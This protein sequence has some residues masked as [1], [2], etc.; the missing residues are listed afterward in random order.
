MK[1]INHLTNRISASKILQNR[2][3]YH[4]TNNLIPLNH[5]RSFNML[6]MKRFFSIITHENNSNEIYSLATFNGEEFLWK[7]RLY[8]FTKQDTND[9]WKILQVYME[10]DTMI[11][12]SQQQQQQQQK[13]SLSMKNIEHIFIRFFKNDVQKSILFWKM[14]KQSGI[15]LN[16][17]CYNIVLQNCSSC[18]YFTHR[19]QKI[20]DEMKDLGHIPTMY[21]LNGMMRD[22]GQ[23]KKMKYVK[24]WYQL[25]LKLG[26][27]PTRKTFNYL[28]NGNLLINNLTAVNHNLRRMEELNLKPLKEHI[29][30]FIKA[31]ALNDRFE[32]LQW[33]FEKFYIRDNL[34]VTSDIYNWVLLSCSKR[35]Q[36]KLAKKYFH[37]MVHE[38]NLR[39]NALTFQYLITA[40]IGDDGFG[41]PGSKE[42]FSE[43]L[44][45]ATYLYKLMKQ[46]Y[47][48]RPTMF[49]CFTLIKSLTYH[50]KFLPLTCMNV[51]PE[52][53]YELLVKLQF[54]INPNISQKITN[55]YLRLL[56]ST[57]LKY[58]YFDEAR[59]VYRIMRIRNYNFAIETASMDLI[60]SYA[61]KGDH[62]SALQIFHE[63]ISNGIRPDQYHYN[64]LLKGYFEKKDFEGG[65]EFFES[66]G[67][68]NLIPSKEVYHTVI[69]AL[70]DNKDIQQARKINQRLIKHYGEPNFINL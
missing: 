28:I 33:T 34:K 65:M 29:D 64:L 27:K 67:S 62:N 45:E 61:K 51:L 15:T 25:Y 32:N 5:K 58:K 47:L 6:E 53:T 50:D 57:L 54:N 19:V 24:R 35:R 46:S 20:W 31:C 44:K 63:M 4:W 3:Y 56:F 55:K 10:N 13:T 41:F 9:I 38:K 23:L 21:T 7:L 11:S 17:N 30:E 43:L 12:N 69:Q 8:L 49:T 68:H 14:L 60:E 70:I 26:Y 40:Q 48:L 59:N 36:R 39:P 2:Y 16:S 1:L 42:N 37:D 22:Y 18:E 66:I 52:L